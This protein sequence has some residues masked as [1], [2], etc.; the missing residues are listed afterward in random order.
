M[1]SEEGLKK[2]LTVFGD[3][4]TMRTVDII[5][6]FSQLL[7]HADGDCVLNSTGTLG[8]IVCRFSTLNFGSFRKNSFFPK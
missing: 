7:T 2:F 6:I 8:T 1:E 3:Q 5:K 4:H